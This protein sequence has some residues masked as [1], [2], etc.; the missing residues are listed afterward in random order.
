MW[1][2]IGFLAA[3]LMPLWNIPLIWH[4]ERRKSSRDISLPWALG[5]WGC[6]LLMLPDGL[7]SADPTFRAFCVVNVVCFTVVVVQ[8]LRYHRP[9]A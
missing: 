4:L 1:H 7:R 8:V 2:T 9:R 6:I 5:V 3:V